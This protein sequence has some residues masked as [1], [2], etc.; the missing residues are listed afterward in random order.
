[1]VG[2]CLG[3]Q[4]SNKNKDK[5]CCLFGKYELSVTSVSEDGKV[6]ITT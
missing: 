2:D 5:D 6:V 1:M 3:D 4:S